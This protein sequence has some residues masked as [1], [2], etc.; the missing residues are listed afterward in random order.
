V[1][2]HGS[3][4][5]KHNLT[6]ADVNRVAGDAVTALTDAVGVAGAGLA[7]IQT[8]IATFD[9]GLPKIP[10]VVQDAL[11][12]LDVQR[13]QLAKEP[14]NITPLDLDNAPAHVK[15]LTLLFGNIDDLVTRFNAEVH[16]APKELDNEFRATSKAITQAAKNCCNNNA[17]YVN[18][19]FVDNQLKQGKYLHNTVTDFFTARKNACLQNPD[20]ERA[21]LLTEVNELLRRYRI[22]LLRDKYKQVCFSAQVPQVLRA[23]L[24]GGTTLLAAE[25]QVRDLRLTP[26][27]GDLRKA[28]GV[29]AQLIWTMWP[30]TS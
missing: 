20:A 4:D 16:R 7:A 17:E 1:A 25:T 21:T 11:T 10:T 26:T 14:A 29:P 12:Q 5:A 3:A 24:S 2:D 18:A 22:F 28:L 30:T 8:G 9:N 19:V 15:S 13:A 6:S 23:C 27:I